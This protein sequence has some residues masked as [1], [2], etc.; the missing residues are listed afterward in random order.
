VADTPGVQPKIITVVRAT[1]D[2]VFRGVMTAGGLT[3]L[4]VLSLIAAFLLFR[5]FEIFRDF[6]FSFLTTS[7]WN[8]GI[9]DQGT[10]ARMGVAAMLVGSIIIA[11]IAI[12]IAVPF[13]MGV[14]CASSTVA[15]VPVDSLARASAVF[16]GYAYRDTSLNSS[17][18]YVSSTTAPRL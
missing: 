13:A 14:N 1:G 6:G 2:K 11:V 4:V 9:D 3:S 17:Y 8:S 15:F 16:R 5:G 12:V 7:E 10:D 18:T